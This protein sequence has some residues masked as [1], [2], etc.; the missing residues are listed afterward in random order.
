[1][2]FRISLVSI[3]ICV[4]HCLDYI[5]YILDIVLKIGIEKWFPKKSLRNFVFSF[6]SIIVTISSSNILNKLFF[7]QYAFRYI[8]KNEKIL[9][10]LML[11][12]YQE[13]AKFKIKEETVT[14]KALKTKMFKCHLSRRLTQIAI[15]CR[16]TDRKIK[17]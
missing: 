13:K 17:S 4:D 5:I 16:K 14:F 3:D 12:A 9:D 6:S 7:L 1:M 2:S 10:N 15:A 8:T 11:I